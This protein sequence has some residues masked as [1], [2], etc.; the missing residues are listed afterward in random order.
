M[1]V[2]IMGLPGH[3][4]TS[5]GL[6]LSKIY[7]A[8]RK[9]V[10]VLTPIEKDIPRWKA[11]GA[12]FVTKNAATFEKVVTDPASF[13]AMLFFDEMRQTVGR[14]PD[15]F[16]TF[17]TQARH[18]G[19]MLHLIGHRATQV[20]PETRGCCTELYCLRQD[21]KSAKLLS[22]QF[23]QE[24]VLKAPELGIKEYIHCTMTKGSARRGKL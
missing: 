9:P 1:H 15:G 24:D 17:V 22:E 19:H 11:A 3:G 12:D 8:K 21:P 4:K 10:G 18:G 16:A 6:E 2:M 23:G 7:K 13:G 5:L 14:R 20:S